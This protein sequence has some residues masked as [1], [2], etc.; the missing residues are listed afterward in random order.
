MQ[1]SLEMT[2]N[3]KIEPKNMINLRNVTKSNIK[4][5]KLVNISKMI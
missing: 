3:T 4:I 5:T 2:V 1:H